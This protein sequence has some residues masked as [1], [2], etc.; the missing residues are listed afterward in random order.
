MVVKFS[1]I[2][3]RNT[4]WKKRNDISQQ[5]RSRS[6][7]IR[8]QADIPKQLRE[9]LQ[10]LYRVENA[11][12][13]TNQYQTVEV[14][15]YRLYLDGSEYSTW[16]LEALS[17]ALRPSTLATKASDHALVFYSK[18]TPLSNHHP[19]PF[20][21]RGRSYANMEQYLAYKRAK[22]SGQKTLIQKALLAQ[23]PVEAIL[24]ALRSDH[25]EEWK[26]EV[27]TIALEGLQAKF[28]QHPALGQYLVSTAPLTLGEASTNHQ[29]GIGLAL[30][31][32]NALDKSKWNKEGNLLG[33]LLMKI[34][35]QMINERQA[36]HMATSGRKP[37]TPAHNKDIQPAVPSSTGGTQPT[38][39]SATQVQVSTNVKENQR[40]WN[41]VNTTNFGILQ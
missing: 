25:Q 26:Q 1:K 7:P 6:N 15:N 23:D 17:T 4:V 27:S 18:H 40:E 24:N 38:E 36:Q 22:L 39:A 9:D 37:S 16:E 34:R 13:K 3:D 31:D 5:G 29:W 33:R 12:Q 8:I 19:A 14:K 21:V 30:E 32:D 35:S 10:I 2:A 41:Q 20:E 11:A 28:R